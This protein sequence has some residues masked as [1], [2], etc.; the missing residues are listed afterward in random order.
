[1][2][3]NRTRT[4]WR[5]QHVDSLCGSAIPLPALVS[6]PI[7]LSALSR[8][9]V[10]VNMPTNPLPYQCGTPGCNRKFGKLEHLRQHAKDFHS[11]SRLPPSG[12][13]P[14]TPPPSRPPP[15]GPPPKQHTF[16]CGAPGCERRAPFSQL[17]LL[18]QHTAQAHPKSNNNTPSD[19]PQLSQEDTQ[20][21]L[22][23][24]DQHGH[25][26]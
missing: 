6:L 21:P 12:S 19:L 22:Q 4:K 25:Q 26:C 24:H 16:R 23:I 10:Q 8:L 15:S 20:F 5:P 2:T 13:P 17:S 14:S 3:R 18:H 9:S 7:V 11:P 1:M